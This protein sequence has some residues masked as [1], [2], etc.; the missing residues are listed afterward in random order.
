MKKPNTSVGVTA[1]V[2]ISKM[3]FIRHGGVTAATMRVSQL[4]GSNNEAMQ[5]E[6]LQAELKRIDIFAKEF[7]KSMV[8]WGKMTSNMMLTLRTWSHS[9]GTVIGLSAGQGSE[10][11]DAFLDV[12]EK[13]LLPLASDLEATI[14]DRILKDLAHLLMSMNHPF[15]L[16]ASMNEQEPY[17]YHLLTAPVNAKKQTSEFARCFEQLSGTPWSACY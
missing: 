10:A 12:V 8:D 1:S 2:G 5:V 11:F 16:I 4:E 7:A 17:H 6:A 14:N 13:G 3:M 15:K 9:F